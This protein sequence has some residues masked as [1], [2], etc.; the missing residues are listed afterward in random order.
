MAGFVDDGKERGTPVRAPEIGTVAGTAGLD[1]DIA[2]SGG[3]FPGHRFTLRAAAGQ[4]REGH[5]DTSEELDRSTFAREGSR[6][7]GW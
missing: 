4:E 5:A 2:G 6:T 1:V 7:P 3:R